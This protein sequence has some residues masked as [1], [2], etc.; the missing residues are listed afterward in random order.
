MRQCL[1]SFF[2]S[3]LVIFPIFTN[4]QRFKNNDHEKILLFTLVVLHP[5][6][7]SLY[8]FSYGAKNGG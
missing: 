3:V 5:P 4:Q 1:V 2:L 6:D 8:K 7:D